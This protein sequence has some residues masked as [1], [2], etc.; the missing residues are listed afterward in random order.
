MT[1]WLTCATT[2]QEAL[3]AKRAEPSARYL[4]GGTE[5]FAK[6]GPA[7]SE[8][9]PIIGLRGIAEWCGITVNVDTVSVGA[10]TTIRDLQ[11]HADLCDRVPMLAQACDA[12]ATRQI[13]ARATV[14]GN[15]AADR[16]DHTLAPC[17]L[18]L[19][20]EVSVLDSGGTQRTVDLADFLESRH[21]MPAGSDA[22]LVSEVSLTPHEGFAAYTRVGRRNGP[23]YAVASSA[24]AVDPAS[25]TIRLGVGN[26]GPTAF[27]PTAAEG[28]AEAEVD[29]AAGRVSDEV[30]Q[31]FGRIA[32]TACDPVTDVEASADYR[33]HA[34]AVMAK[35]LLTRAFE[36]A[37]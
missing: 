37:R 7:G 27:R 2:V 18:A 22:T 33:R 16:A 24:L 32:A 25:R 11:Q 4:A 13:R 14:G 21:A 9:V 1:A 26:A 35:R 30:C 6:L 20:A 12:L 17:L 15:L 36:E 10:N 19:E 34:V 23:C 8:R 29:W 3:A 5:L 31:E 28:F